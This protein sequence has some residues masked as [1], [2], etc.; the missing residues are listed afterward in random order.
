MELLICYHSCCYLNTCS[1]P[2]PP[3]HFCQCCYVNSISSCPPFPPTLTPKSLL[4]PV[5]WRVSLL[6][7]LP[8]T[9]ESV[10]YVQLSVKFCGD[11]N[12]YTVFRMTGRWPTAIK[13]RI[14]A[15]APTHPP[16]HHTP[17]LLLAEAF[18]QE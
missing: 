3:P 1:C 8:S 18:R 15:P 6:G 2:Q 14:A 12:R 4:P 13:Q 11:G 16:L 10:S 7:L 9:S 17:S 5:L